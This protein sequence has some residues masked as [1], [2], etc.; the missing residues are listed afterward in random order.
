MQLPGKI[1]QHLFSLLTAM[2]VVIN[3]AF[4]ITPLFI[5]ALLKLI[6]RPIAFL[7]NPL[8]QLIEQVYRIAAA[9]DSLWMLRVVG[10]QVRIHGTMPDHPA[11]IIIANH[12]SWFDIPL[13]QY[14]ITHQGPILKF[15]IKRELIWVP[16]VGWIC[17]ALGFPRLNRGAGDNAREKDYAAIESATAQL[18][19]EPGGLLVFAEGTRFT[20]TKHANQRS[21]FRHLLKPRPGGLKIALAYLPKDTPVIDV[22]INY[23]GGETHFWHCLHGANRCIDITLTQYTAGSITDARD[24]LEARW[25]EKDELLTSGQSA[26]K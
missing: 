25:Y 22:T 20:P 17:W 2:V 7:R 16:V 18:S 15:L 11:P 12:Q 9:I 13:L 8:N 1:G 6:T 26:S 19:G 5:L 23:N 3:L 21:P 4:W 24:W 14:A 10:V